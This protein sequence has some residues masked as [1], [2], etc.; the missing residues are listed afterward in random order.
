MAT[1]KQ[2]T[3]PVTGEVLIFR[4]QS[5]MLNNFDQFFGFVF[6]AF[7]F[8]LIYFVQ[9][10]GVYDF[11]GKDDAVEVINFVLHG[12]GGQAFQFEADGF[13]VN[14]LA[15]YGDKVVAF[16]VAV[17]AGYAQAAFFTDL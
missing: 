17:P 2:N 9:A 3:P 7:F 13:A 10:G 12:A 16:Y 1:S 5:W 11:V 8:G 15:F 14:I 6:V 4:L